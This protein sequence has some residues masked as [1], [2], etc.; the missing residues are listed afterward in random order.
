M[1][2]MYLQNSNHRPIW[3]EVTKDS[4]LGCKLPPLISPSA[5]RLRTNNPRIVE[6]YNKELY[7]HLDA[8]GVFHRTH[9]LLMRFSTPMTEQQ[10]REFEKLDKIRNLAMIRAERKCRNLKMGNIK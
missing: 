7:N 5:R 9:R 1:S 4:F 3:V 10:I 8:H 2:Y 6:K